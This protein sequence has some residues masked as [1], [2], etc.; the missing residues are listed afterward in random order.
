MLAV[1]LPS[2]LLAPGCQRR[3]LPHP[4]T[5]VSFTD[6]TTAAGIRFVH[7]N[8]AYGR[9]LYPEKMGSGAAFFDANGDGLLD[10]FLVNGAPLPGHPKP[11][12]QP[13]R[14]YINSGDGTFEDR[15]AASGLT[16]VGY[17]M[18][19]AVGDVDNDG[20]EDLYVTRLRQNSLYLN[21]GRGAFR[22][23]TVAA[24]AGVGGYSSSAVF[25]DFD[26]DGWLDL[27]VCRNIP[28]NDPKDDY[29]CLNSLGEKQYCSVHVYPGLEHRLLRNTGK[30]HFRDVTRQSGISG[31]IGRGLAATCGDYDRDGDV[32]LFVAN[33][34][35]PNFLWQ[36]QGD[37]RFIEVAA[38]AGF[39]Y[40][41]AGVATA[42]MG[43]DIADADGDG[44]DDV[45]ESDFQG[46]RKTLYFGSSEGFFVPNAGAKGLGDMPVE[47]LGFGIGF[48]DFDLDSWPDIFIANGHVN[49]DLE[50]TEQIPFAQTAQ[51]FRNQGKGIYE[52]SSASLGEYA[53]VRRVGRGAAF[54]DYD[55]DGDTDILVV[56]NGQAPALLRNDHPHRHHWLGVRCIGRQSNRSGLGALVTITTRD[57]TVT[58]EVR[59]AGSYLSSNDP[60][61]L[62]GL[63][64]ADRVERL[65]VRW[66][67][68]QTQELTHLPVDRYITITE[69]ETA[70]GD[71]DGDPSQRSPMMSRIKFGG[72]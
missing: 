34:E 44:A 9:K 25:F 48:L 53:S 23:V 16:T 28:W 55:N 5:P 26:R 32:D 43:L 67:S 33:D 8:G 30:G 11:R 7:D 69:G 18:G 64:A 4:P 19:V 38:V 62:F 3:S 51:L 52:D 35:S 36:N 22:D 58:R 42:G 54:G 60:R 21:D 13:S 49:D 50:R 29:V 72:P 41:D 45:I 15:T 59:T 31:K 24:G 39:A 57:R 70:S 37:G 47:R 10:V 61:V 40:N 14:L 65:T 1:S 20:D 27:Y 71:R 68:G 12:P 6:V 2:L 66:S 17:G 63:G 46:Q 56:N